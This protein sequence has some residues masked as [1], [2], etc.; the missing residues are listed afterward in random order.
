MQ[1]IMYTWDHSLDTC[2]KISE[3]LIFLTPGYAHA[4]G[5]FYARTK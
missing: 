1:S 2:A 5:T 3:K 4:R